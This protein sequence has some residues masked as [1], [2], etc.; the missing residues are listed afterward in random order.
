M[1]AHA[2]S[3]LTAPRVAKDTTTDPSSECSDSASALTSLVDSGQG[4]AAIITAQRDGTDI[5]PSPSS[6]TTNAGSID[7]YILGTPITLTPRGRSTTTFLNEG[8]LF[9]TSLSSEII[10]GGSL[11]HDPEKWS[12]AVVP[13]P[14]A[15]AKNAIYPR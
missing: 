12:E 7:H 15:L 10:H 8:E 4:V 14:R 5:K 2:S 9:T 11:L 1:E 13:A 3:T 6:G